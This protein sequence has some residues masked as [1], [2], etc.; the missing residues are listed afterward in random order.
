M[1]A[2]RSTRNEALILAWAGLIKSGLQLLTP[3][4]LVR[5]LD[6]GEFGEYRIFWLVA[7]TAALLLPLGMA[8]SLLFFIPKAEAHER[9]RYVSQTMAYFLGI[10]IIA[11]M[12]L[13][14]AEYWLPDYVSSLTDPRIVL[15]SFTFLWLLSQPLRYLPNADQNIRLQAGF[16]I[17]ISLLRAATVILAAWLTEDLQAVFRALLVWAAFQLVILIYYIV[18][19]HRKG[20]QIPSS[21]GLREQLNF[22]VPFGLARLLSG[23]GRQ[24]DQWIVTLLFAP[25]SLG[26]YTI[27][28]SFFAMLNLGRTALANVT[29][30]KMSSSHATGDTERALELNN[31]GNIVICAVVFPAAFYLWIFAEPVLTVLYTA[32][33][34]S[35]VPVLRISLIT[36]LLKCVEL[37]SILMIFEQGRFVAR[38][39]GGVLVLSIG[40]SYAGALIFGLPGVILGSVVTE[41]VARFVNFRRAAYLLGIP[42]RELQDWALIFRIGL[43]ALSVGFVAGVVGLV[44]FDEYTPLMKALIGGIVV[45]AAYIPVLFLF[46]LGWLVR[47]VSGRQKWTV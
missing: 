29:L 30:P 8:R 37:G 25:A 26:I 15:V 31:R 4:A 2:R 38:V 12:A 35:A 22:A 7:N 3:I 27:G 5:L 18:T 6:P 39:S 45:A 10:A 20:L 19:R 41:L 43:A 14:Y 36:L 46:R 16:I 9:A 1:S 42:F 47:V 21:A 28:T 24:A 40:V 34:V 44:M 23:S 11:G 33:Y 13:L 32:Q 17:A